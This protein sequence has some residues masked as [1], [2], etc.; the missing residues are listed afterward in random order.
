MRTLQFEDPALGHDTLAA[1]GC[2]FTPGPSGEG[3][4]GVADL[5]VDCQGS[6]VDLSSKLSKDSLLL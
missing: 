1:A 2:K 3:G 4:R 6:V 5:E